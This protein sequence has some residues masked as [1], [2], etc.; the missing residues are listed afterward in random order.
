MCSPVCSRKILLGSCNESSWDAWP[1][2]AYGVKG[3]QLSY[4]QEAKDASEVWVKRIGPMK[5]NSRM[6]DP[7]QGDGPIL[8]EGEDWGGTKAPPLHVQAG[9]SPPPLALID[10]ILLMSSSTVPW[11]FLVYSHD[12]GNLG[13]GHGNVTPPHRLR[14]NR[15]NKFSLRWMKSWVMSWI[16]LQTL[17]CS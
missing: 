8:W 2:L 4:L 16:C 3:G 12:I 14:R 1:E 13:V 9:A 10:P 15:G 7:G 11:K 6:D 5:L 17:P